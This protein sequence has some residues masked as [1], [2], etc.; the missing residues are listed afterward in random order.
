MTGPSYVPAGTRT[1]S[2]ELAAAISHRQRARRQQAV[3]GVIEQ[4]VVAQVGNV[5]GPDGVDPDGRV[6]LE[7]AVSI[8]DQYEREHPL[9]PVQYIFVPGGNYWFIEP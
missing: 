8:I 1:V 4:L 6:T 9:L 3:G 2:P 5:V 7:V